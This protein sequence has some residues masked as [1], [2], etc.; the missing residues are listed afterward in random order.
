MSTI[1]NAGMVTTMR[2]RMA[3]MTI[4]DITITPMR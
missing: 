2:L 1:T 3:I 4:T